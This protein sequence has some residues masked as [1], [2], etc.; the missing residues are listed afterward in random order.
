VHANLRRKQAIRKQA[1]RRKRR[2]A[3]RLDKRDLR[4][5]DR[6]AMTA[7]G[8]RYERAERSVATA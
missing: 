8:V 3:R 1:A 5:C 6:P 4:G 7:S 2:I